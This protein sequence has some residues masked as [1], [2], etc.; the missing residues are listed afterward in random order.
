MP[1]LEADTTFEGVDPDLVRQLRNAV[2]R[3]TT[4][5][6]ERDRLIVELH[7]QGASLRAIGE[8]AGMSH[9]GVQRVLDRAP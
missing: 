2:K 8:V 6:E 9:A 4:A 1:D 3:A 5:T 7:R